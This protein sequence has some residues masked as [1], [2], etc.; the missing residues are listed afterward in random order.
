MR[1]SRRVLAKLVLNF[2]GIKRASSKTSPMS[3]KMSLLNITEITTSLILTE[4]VVGI[5]VTMSRVIGNITKGDLS[6]NGHKR[7]SISR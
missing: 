4:K 2:V 1:L 7:S 5:L 6:R 3:R